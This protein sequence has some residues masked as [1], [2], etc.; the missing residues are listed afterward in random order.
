M[1]YLLLQGLREM[2][3]LSSR[4]GSDRPTAPPTEDKDVQ[5]DGPPLTGAWRPAP[6]PCRLWM[7]GCSAPLIGRLHTSC[8][9]IWNLTART[10]VLNSVYI[11]RLCNLCVQSQS[12]YTLV[13]VW[14][15]WKSQYGYKAV[16]RH[17]MSVI[18]GKRWYPV[19]PCLGCPFP[20][21]IPIPLSRGIRW[22]TVMHLL[23]YD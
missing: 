19:W 22:L 20:Q 12:N 17:Y 7:C 18:W 14:F 2:L 9:H 6:Q 11:L 8:P 23:W 15:P 4:Y 16:W 5:T 10:S 13:N 1:S 21:F 3:D